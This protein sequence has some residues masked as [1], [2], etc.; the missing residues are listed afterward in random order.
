MPCHLAHTAY[1]LFLDGWQG[2][3]LFHCLIIFLDGQLQ[4]VHAKHLKTT[5]NAASC[6]ILV[7]V[8]LFLF[9]NISSILSPRY[10][11]ATKSSRAKAYIV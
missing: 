2:F 6:G 4:I 11:W 9:G 1:E 7:S 3:F 5:L 8:E 10:Q